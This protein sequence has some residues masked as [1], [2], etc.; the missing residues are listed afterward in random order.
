MSSFQSS[1]LHLSTDLNL[2]RLFM[3]TSSLILLFVSF[4]LSILFLSIL[5]ILSL[6]T[7]SRC[8]ER[9][10]GSLFIWFLPHLI[11]SQVPGKWGRE[12]KSVWKMENGV[13]IHVV[14]PFFFLCAIFL[15]EAWVC[16]TFVR[17]E[18]TEGKHNRGVWDGTEQQG[19]EE[20]RVRKW[21]FL[22]GCQAVSSQRKEGTRGERKNVEV[23]N[24]FFPLKKVTVVY[25]LKIHCCTSLQLP[26]LCLS[27]SFPHSPL[28]PRA[29]F[30][31]RPCQFTVTL[32]SLFLIFPFFISLHFLSQSNIHGL[33]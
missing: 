25:Q 19:T 7:S 32:F 27:P 8:R 13:F 14:L 33:L 4:T 16:R 1:V 28:P 5:S 17:G 18:K 11:S 23:S 2:F 22:K 3:Y 12:K 29:C 26:S 15:P 24:L 6:S 10:G 31:K 20:E 30:Q 9:G 21:F